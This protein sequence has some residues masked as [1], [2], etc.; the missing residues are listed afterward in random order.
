MI[1]GEKRETS[2]FLGE[3]CKK[4]KIVILNT[5]LIQNL[6]EKLDKNESRPYY[7]KV[8]IDT[9]YIAFIPFRS[10]IQHKHC[11]KTNPSELRGIDF[12]KSIIV[13]KSDEIHWIKEVTSI[14]SQQWKKIKQN[15]DMIKFL[16]LNYVKKYKKLVIKGDIENSIVKFSTLQ[17]YHQELDI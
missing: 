3:S 2:F 12:T 7:C 16:Y 1:S 6:K 13:E 11:F 8:E 17:N 5:N 9:K 10:N 14:E 4:M 15:Q